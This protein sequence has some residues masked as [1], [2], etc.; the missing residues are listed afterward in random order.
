MLPPSSTNLASLASFCLCLSL[1]PAITPALAQGTGVPSGARLER[2]DLSDEDLARV[3]AVTHPA[4][5]FIRAEKYE[6]MSGGRGT[7]SPEPAKDA[8]SHPILPMDG[9]ERQTF[10]LGLAIFKKLWVSAPASTKAS[11]GLGPLYN[12]RSCLRCHP[13]NGRGHAPDSGE[14]DARGFLMR[15][16]VP[17]ETDADQQRL[18]GKEIT[19]LPD[20]VYGTQLQ[21]RA[22]PGLPAEAWTDVSYEPIPVTLAD[23]TVIPL[24]KPTFTSRNWGYGAPHPDLMTS[25]RIATAM[26]GLGLV[27]AIHP[28][29][30]LANADPQDKDKRRHFGPGQLGAQRAYRRH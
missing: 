9:Q 25:P 10:R 27:E 1:F 26:I 15:L 30:I 2:N 8:Y 19:S 28:S 24:R 13:R 11:D 3:K 18:T 17:P 6:A 7:A 16:S 12:A 23:G 22:L 20:P 5:T 21:D 4:S 29:D 14:R